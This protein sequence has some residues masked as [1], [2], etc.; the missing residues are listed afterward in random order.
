MSCCLQ[1]RIQ[2]PVKHP[3]YSKAMNTFAKSSILDVWEASGGKRLWRRP[4]S[5]KFQLFKYGS[6]TD[7]FL[8]VFQTLFY[9]CPQNIEKKG[10]PLDND[11]VWCKISIVLKDLVTIA[12]FFLLGILIKY[13]LATNFFY[14]LYTQ[15][16]SLPLVILDILFKNNS[17]LLRVRFFL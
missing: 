15:R 14:F 6:A 17:Y 7:V 4:L 16:F 10:I 12:D 13:L 11:I 9:G 1:R 5:V 2:N 8:S 3:W